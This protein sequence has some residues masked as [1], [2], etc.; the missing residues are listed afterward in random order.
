M[1]E[2]Q[3]LTARQLQQQQKAQALAGDSPEVQQSALD[4]AREEVAGFGDEDQDQASAT[5]GLRSSL[6]A[7]GGGEDEAMPAD[8][9]DSAVLD[10]PVSELSVAE[11]AEAPPQTQEP[12]PI[13]ETAA[14]FGFSQAAKVSVDERVDLFLEAIRNRSWEQ[15]GRQ[16]VNRAEGEDSELKLPVDGYSELGS[17][18]SGKVKGQMLNSWRT[19]FPGQTYE[20][21]VQLSALY[22]FVCVSCLQRLPQEH[23]ARRCQKA[24]T[25]LVTKCVKAASKKRWY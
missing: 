24:F 16:P 4:D 21:E 10:R 25:L 23:T 20:P 13:V 1:K 3:Q 6:E 22:L 17:I 19:F 9:P 5:P 8:T 15:T 2:Q 7:P 18:S 11:P 14:P 12:E